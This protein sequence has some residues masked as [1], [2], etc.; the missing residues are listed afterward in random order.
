MLS[1]FS[2]NKNG[3]FVNGNGENLSQ[4]QTIVFKIDSAKLALK[5]NIA[6]NHSKKTVAYYESYVNSLEVKRSYVNSDQSLRERAEAGGWF[7][8]IDNQIAEAKRAKNLLLKIQ[9]NEK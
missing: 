1:V 3:K 9:N 5:N 6:T 4:S 2:Q 7:I 8:F